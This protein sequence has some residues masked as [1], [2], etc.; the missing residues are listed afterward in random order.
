MATPYERMGIV[1][2][3]PEGGIR[4]DLARTTTE[5]PWVYEG[6]AFTRDVEHRVRASIDAE[7]NVVVDAEGSLPLEVVRRV[8]LLL[9]NACKRAPA[10]DPDGPPPRRLHR[11]RAE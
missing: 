11:W 6:S 4:F 9:R 3:H 7:G 10:A 2:D 8:R 1:G 5:P